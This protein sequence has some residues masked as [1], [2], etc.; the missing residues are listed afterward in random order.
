MKGPHVCSTQDDK[1]KTTTRIVEITHTPQHRLE[2][3]KLLGG[4][5]RIS[6]IQ[7]DYNERF[8]L[9]F[10]QLCQ[11][12]WEQNRSPWQVPIVVVVFSTTQTHQSNCQALGRI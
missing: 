4:L 12:L 7:V 10:C 1:D 11:H 8:L 6:F 5:N 3:R 2:I 9:R